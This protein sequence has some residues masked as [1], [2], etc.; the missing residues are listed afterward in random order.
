[1]GLKKNDPWP[2]ESYPWCK[3]PKGTSIYSG[4]FKT[5]CLIMS[6]ILLNNVNLLR[7]I[8]SRPVVLYLPSSHGISFYLTG[9]EGQQERMTD[10]TPIPSLNKTWYT[11]SLCTISTT[12]FLFYLPRIRKLGNSVVVVGDVLYPYMK[13]SDTTSVNGVDTE[14]KKYS[15]IRNVFPCEVLTRVRGKTILANHFL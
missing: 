13:T 8:H 5:G 10:Y 4:T 2:N 11:Y 7:Y 15:S 12:S 9:T 14:S 1:M 6:R 3:R